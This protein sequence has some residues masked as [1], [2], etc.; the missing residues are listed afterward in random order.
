M[1]FVLHLCLTD[2]VMPSSH[3]PVA[4]T[5]A[6]PQVS[7]DS[8]LLEVLMWNPNWLDEYGM[9]C[10]FINLLNFIQCRK[11]FSDKSK[12]GSVVSIVY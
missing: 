5:E 1:R 6:L 9:S 10:A 8:C 2:I 12:A 3:L 7:V 11:K 4:K